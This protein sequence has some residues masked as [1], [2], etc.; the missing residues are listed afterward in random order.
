M[1]VKK[2]IRKFVRTLAKEFEPERVILFGS[3]AGGTPTKDSDVDLMVIMRHKGDS[4]DQ[5][6][7]I[8]RRID[9]P[10][11]LD[12]IVKTPAEARKRLRGR[13]MFVTRVFRD[14]NTLYERQ[15]QRVD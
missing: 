3:Y 14:G 11:P 10:F 5:A 15:R 13:D 6:L 2:D 1:I 4:V 7:A 8:R 9:C 12:L